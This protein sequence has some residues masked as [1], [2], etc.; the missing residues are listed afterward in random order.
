MSFSQLETTTLGDTGITVTRLGA[1]GHFTNGPLAHEDIPRRI[2]ELNHLLDLGVTYFDVQWE[3]EEIATAEVM[4]TRSEEFT[5]AWPLHGVSKL[6]ADL[7]EEYILNYCDDH[8]SRFGIEHVGILLWVSLV[9]QS[10]TEDQVMNEVRSAFTTLKGQ[11]FCDHLAFSCHLSPDMALRAIREYD[12]FDVMMVPYCPLHPAAEKTL[13]PT[14]KAKGIGTVGM[15]PF[16]GGGGFFNK[17]WAAEFNDVLTDRWHHSTRPYE[18]A[19]RWVMEN[20]DLDCTVPAAHSIQQIDEL[21]KAVNES[22]TEEDNEILNVFRAAM[23]NSGVECQLRGQT[24]EAG[25][26]D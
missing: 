19:L 21:C 10:E 4:K 5:V 7:T 2:Q 1:G 3:P 15:K 8:R 12:D 11:G 20:K 24:G 16:G 26:W 25:A 18:A 17:V 22:F 6:G 14:A 23:D 13:L 9:L